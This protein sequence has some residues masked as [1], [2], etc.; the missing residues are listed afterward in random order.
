MHEAELEHILI[1]DSID[2]MFLT[3]VDNKLIDC[4]YK[5]NEYDTIIHKKKCDSEKTRLIALVKH[6]IRDDVKVRE[7]FMIEDYPNIWLE[8]IDSKSKNTLLG[9]FIECGAKINIKK[10]LK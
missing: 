2:I 5:I 3:E 10:W 8:Y 9:R 7:E 6:S 4:A 1:K